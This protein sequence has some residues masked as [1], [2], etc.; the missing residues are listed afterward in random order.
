M[1]DKPAVRI[2]TIDGPTASGKGTIASEVAR[3]LGF[4]YLDSGA[5]F[6]LAAL[7]CLTQKVDLTDEAACSGVTRQ[8]RPC[9]K[10]GKVFL[11]DKDVTDA[12]REEAVGL[13]AS[14]VATMASVRTAILD[15]ERDFCRAPG[16]VADGRDMGTVVFPNACLKVFLTAGAQVRAQRRYKQL[17]QRG[18]SA[19]LADL[20]RDLQERDKRDRE[21]AVS[22]TRPA[23]DARLL[24]SSDQTIEQTV[25]CVL[26][27]YCALES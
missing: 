13:A 9:F 6:R 26:D 11:G 14:R 18:I 8:M 22:P 23:P 24:D 10:D 19:N 25:R 17:I 16:L 7:S 5:L 27:W 2:I 15:L 1:D 20:A 3:K 12:I 21:R 4:H